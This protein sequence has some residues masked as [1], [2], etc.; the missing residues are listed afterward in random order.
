LIL[1]RKCRV[2]EH[3]VVKR[4]YA[5]KVSLDRRNGEDCFVFKKRITIVYLKM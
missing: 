1:N 3:T 4:N 5:Q 2:V